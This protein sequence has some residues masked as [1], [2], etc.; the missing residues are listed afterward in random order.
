M[1][2]PPANPYRVTREFTGPPLTRSQQR[3][4]SALV[5]LCPDTGCEVEARAVAEQAQLRLGSVVLVLRA[6]E[7]QR[8]ALVH[9]AEDGGPDC[10]APTLT[11]RSRVRHFPAR[12]HEGAQAESRG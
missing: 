11:G 4:L 9:L 7:K 2:E 10:W 8:L 3:V 5:A 12:A 1:T 6:L